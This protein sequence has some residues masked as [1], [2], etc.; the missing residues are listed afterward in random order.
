MDVKESETLPV[1]PTMAPLPAVAAVAPAARVLPVNA[2]GEDFEDEVADDATR[3]ESESLFERF[4]W[5]YAFFRERMFR[6]D[7]E[8]ISAALWPQGMPP[9]GSRFLELGCGPGFYCCQFGEQ[10]R[11]LRVLGIDRSRQQLR[12]AQRNARKRRLENVRFEQ[13]D[14]LHLAL[15]NESVDSLLAARLFTI[16][17]QREE[18]M[19]EMHRVLRTGGRCFIAEP[20]SRLRAV[21]P[22][23]IMW[24][25]ANLL[26]LCGYSRTRAY[27]EPPDA[28]VLAPK[29]F[30]ALVH[31]QPW[32]AVTRWKDVHYQYA[33]CEKGPMD[34]KTPAPAAEAKAD[35]YTI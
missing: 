35:D 12:H 21:L 10:F 15:D 5:L 2:G 23:R 8:G 20:C 7:T 24:G 4:G 17:P 30:G 1:E 34:G 33:I 3:P 18:A 9:E 11:D 26:A 31:S 22:L 13:S 27:R 28:T 14:A 29:E 19:A 25:V 6:D 32:R 16:L